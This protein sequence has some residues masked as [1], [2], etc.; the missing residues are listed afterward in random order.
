MEKVMRLAGS[1]GTNTKHLNA[2]VGINNLKI[3]ASISSASQGGTRDYN[4]LLNKP[5]INSVE[6]IGN[7]TS[8]ELFVQDAMDEISEQDID[9]IVFGGL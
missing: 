6:L 9:T 3:N 5:S 2:S 8:A 1:L 4:K 7:K